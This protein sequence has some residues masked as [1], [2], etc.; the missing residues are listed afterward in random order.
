MKY[1]C[2]DCGFIFCAGVHDN[3]NAE[4]IV[5]I[6]PCGGIGEEYIVEEEDM[7]DRFFELN[8]DGSVIESQDGKFVARSDY[9]ELKKQIEFNSQNVF[10]VVHITNDTVEESWI[11][12]NLGRAVSFFREKLVYFDVNDVDSAVDRRFSQW[13]NGSLSIINPLSMVVR[14]GEN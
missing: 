1:K 4:N 8:Q 12:Y 5:K 2:S 3:K 11:F 10:I 9:N 14:N 6:C 13:D 7:K